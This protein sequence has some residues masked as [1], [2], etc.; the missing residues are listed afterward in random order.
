MKRKG[1]IKL[2]FVLTVWQLYGCAD[3]TSKVE[4]AVGDLSMDEHSSANFNEVRV[5][6]LSWDVEV[7]FETKTISGTAKW[8][9]ENRTGGNV[10]VLDTRQLT[11][12]SVVLDNG[13]DADFGLSKVDSV[14]GQSLSI[15]IPRFLIY[16]FSN[17]KRS[18]IVSIGASSGSISEFIKL[19]K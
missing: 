10:L 17:F 8:N 7:D 19:L 2:C 5:K 12:N 4:S 9:I 16:A 11:I 15:E 6:H 14:F 1:I 13:K 18:I 3:K